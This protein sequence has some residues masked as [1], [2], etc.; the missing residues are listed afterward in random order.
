MLT[1]FRTE[2]QIGRLEQSGRLL[3][4]RFHGPI[5]AVAAQDLGDTLKY[6]NIEQVAAQ[7]FDSTAAAWAQVQSNM[8]QRANSLEIFG[9]APFWFVACP[10][11][12]PSAFFAWVGLRGWARNAMEKDRPIMAASFSTDQLIIGLA[13]SAEFHDRLSH[14]REA[15]V[16]KPLF[17]L[18]FLLNEDALPMPIREI[19]LVA[20]EHVSLKPDD[21]QAAT[22]SLPLWDQ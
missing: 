19:D 15:P 12:P 20:G 16:E 1:V 14:A 5:F 4:V 7:G 11:W 3:R 8:A 6:V 2:D 10:G 22:I 13:D 9:M 18:P 17:S 21:P